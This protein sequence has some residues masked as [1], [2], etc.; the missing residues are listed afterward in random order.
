MPAVGNSVECACTSRTVAGCFHVR[1][2]YHF[3][4]ISDSYRTS[5]APRWTSFILPRTLRVWVLRGPSQ[6]CSACLGVR[7]HDLCSSACGYCCLGLVYMGLD[8]LLGRNERCTRTCP[9]RGLSSV[10]ILFHPSLDDYHSIVG[11][12]I[13]L[14]LSC[15]SNSQYC[16]DFVVRHHFF[17]GCKCADQSRHNFFERVRLPCHSSQEPP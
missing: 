9:P 17:C 14:L 13:L 12:G 8:E 15:S 3:S 10:D 2:D 5:K 1:R 7:T 6:Y 16:G 4:G 11:E